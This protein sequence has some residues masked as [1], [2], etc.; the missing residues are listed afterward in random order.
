MRY[1]DYAERAHC[2]ECGS[3]VYM[4]YDHQPEYIGIAAGTIDEGSVKGVLPKADHHIFLDEKAGWYDLPG[5]ETGKY[6]KH[7]P[8][9]QEGLDASRKK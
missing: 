5:D 1:S 6:A 2:P 4:K 8:A 7:R 9:F 3:T